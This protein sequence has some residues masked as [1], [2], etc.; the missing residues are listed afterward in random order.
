LQVD[1]N[2]GFKPEFV[3]EAEQL[4]SLQPAL[5]SWVEAFRPCFKKQ[6]TFIHFE[7]YLLGL[8]ADLRRKSVEPIA[9]AAGVAVRTMQEFLS[10]FAWDHSRMDKMLSHRVADRC[11]SGG[12]G[13]IDATGHPKRGDKTPG[14]HRQYCGESGK[15][16]N[17]VVAQHLLFTDNDAVNPFD[18]VLASELYLPKCWADDR[19]RCEEAGIGPEIVYR[20]KWQIAADQ[21][22]DALA[23]GVKLN[24]VVFDEDY[25]RIPAFWF[26]LDAM[27]QQAVGE[28]PCDFRAWV[29]RPACLSTGN[30]AHAAR[31]VDNLAMHSP[32]FTSQAWK[33]CKVK[34]TTRGELV[35]E[36]KAARVHLS[37]SSSANHNVSV[38]TDRKYWLIGMRQQK[39]GEIKYVI[40]NAGEG[41]SVEQLVRVLLSRWHVE[42]WF[43][44]AKQEAGLGAFEV[45]TFKSLTRHWLCVRLAMCFLSEQTRRLRGEKSADHLR[46]SF[47]GGRD[48][49]KQ[50]MEPRLA[51]LVSVD[52]PMWVSSAKECRRI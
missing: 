8:L 15:I 44:R 24:W 48:A 46:A 32:A 6:V 14:V 30:A 40:S 33:R 13:V 20:P 39:T 51:E 16:D 43:E 22:R 49:G 50:N 9:L 3:M 2:F 1:D 7:C 26:K 41:E 25:G 11:P 21:V 28:V 5:R 35:W 47:R 38:P 19:E 12:I 23:N 37:N 29:K 42:K 27:G 10:Q 36:Y 34:D 45:R 31:R 4:Q 18:C 52:Q 17:C